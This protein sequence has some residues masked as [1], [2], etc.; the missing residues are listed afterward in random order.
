MSEILSFLLARPG[1]LAA[2]GLVWFGSWALARFWPRRPVSDRD[3]RLIEIC[4][5]AGVSRGI[6]YGK[7][8]FII[9]G[10]E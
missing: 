6:I 4:G 2:G 9:R 5:R 3:R 8:P 10:R 7:A 1:L